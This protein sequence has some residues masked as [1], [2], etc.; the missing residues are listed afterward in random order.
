MAAKDLPPDHSTRIE[1]KGVRTMQ[2]PIH[3]TKVIDAL[4]GE[5]PD[6]KVTITQTK[7]G[8]SLEI[9]P[10]GIPL[11]AVGLMLINGLLSTAA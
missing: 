7:E 4:T 8:M 11:Q 1:P 5:Q 2:S 10:S 9:D 6:V 3:D